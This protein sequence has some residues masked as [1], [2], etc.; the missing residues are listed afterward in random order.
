MSS[1]NVVKP[2]ASVK[3]QTI[4]RSQPQTI[5]QVVERIK[6]DSSLSGPQKAA[7]IKAIEN[8]VARARYHAIRNERADVKAKRTEYN[9]RKYQTEKSLLAQAKAKGYLDKPISFKR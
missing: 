8:K 2:I 9:R 5:E 7:M 6:R 4:D 1:N 3:S